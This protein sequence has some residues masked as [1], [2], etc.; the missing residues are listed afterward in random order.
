MEAVHGWVWI[1]SGIAQCHH[2]AIVVLK[3]AYHLYAHFG[4]KFLSNGNGILWATKNRNGIELYHL[5][6]TGKF[7]AFSRLEAWHRQSKQMVQN[8]LVISVKTGKR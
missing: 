7:F 4:E 1:F 3:S 8:I 6:N 2:V 5:Q